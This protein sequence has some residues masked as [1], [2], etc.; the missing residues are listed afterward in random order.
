[1]QQ[2]ASISV[3]LITGMMQWHDAATLAYQ[4]TSQ[5]TPSYAGIV[6]RPIFNFKPRLN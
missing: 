1:M 4:E 3:L 6:G 5:E 2:A